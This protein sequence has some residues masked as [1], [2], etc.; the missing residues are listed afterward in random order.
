VRQFVL[1]LRRI[2][3]FNALTRRAKVALAVGAARA[4][5]TKANDK[6]QEEVWEG[7]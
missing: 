6:K 1:P 7:M 5:K 2:A 4:R 3:F